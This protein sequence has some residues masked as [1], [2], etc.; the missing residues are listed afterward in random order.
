MKIP[1]LLCAAACVLMLAGNASAKETGKATKT[2][3]ANK[4]QMAKPVQPK[5]PYANYWNDPGRAAPPFSYRGNG[6]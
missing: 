1:T 5:D 4:A 2:H 3:R 6:I